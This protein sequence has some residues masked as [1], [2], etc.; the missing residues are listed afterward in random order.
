MTFIQKSPAQELR[1]H[2]K[3]RL[4]IK[5]IARQWPSLY[6]DFR[7]G[8]LSESDVRERLWEA[9]FS[10]NEAYDV[11]EHWANELNWEEVAADHRSAS[12]T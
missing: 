11:A 10:A 2:C 9:G 5:S 6:G 3:H 7:Q 1:E 4:H 8:F 12:T